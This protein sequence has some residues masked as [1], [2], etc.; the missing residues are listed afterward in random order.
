MDFYI[1]MKNKIRQVFINLRNIAYTRVFRRYGELSALSAY[2]VELYTYF[3][4][5]SLVLLS[6]YS[7]L[8]FELG[9]GFSHGSEDEKAK[10]ILIYSAAFLLVSIIVFQII[11]Q[12]WIP[13]S[14]P[15]RYL[16]G[17]EYKQMNRILLILVFGP[18]AL[19]FMVLAIVVK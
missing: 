8:K 14:E 6:L 9:L 7:L 3:L 10:W 19:L 4:S 5:P 18:L 11:F 12:V 13:K 1:S 16:E 15:L 2:K 17:K